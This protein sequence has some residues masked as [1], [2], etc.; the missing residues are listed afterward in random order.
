MD[1]I[2][3]TSRVR[4]PHWVLP[5]IK[6][7]SMKI[8]DLSWKSLVSEGH[9]LWIHCCPPYIYIIY[10]IPS[11]K[12]PHNY[13]KIQRSTM[14]LRGKSTISTGPCLIAMLVIT[15][16]Y[17]W[18]SCCS[19]FV[20]LWCLI[21]LLFVDTLICVYRNVRIFEISYMMPRCFQLAMLNYE[22]VSIKQAVAETGWPTSASNARTLRV[23]SDMASCID[24]LL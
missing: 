20:G 17:I 12:Q 7:P 9:H 3:K 22:S 4:N 6:W 11:G 1:I 24:D 2:H 19:N 14:L 16:G 18:V 21:G 10:Y 13:G 5:K 15:R 23:S 8:T